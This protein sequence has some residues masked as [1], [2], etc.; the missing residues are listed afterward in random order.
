M[1]LFLGSKYVNYL[2][3]YAFIDKIEALRYLGLQF[4]QA[5]PYFGFFEAGSCVAQT[6]LYVAEDDS[7]ELLVFLCWDYHVHPYSGFS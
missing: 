2:D 4:S 5:A 3:H 1:F 7:D 6:D